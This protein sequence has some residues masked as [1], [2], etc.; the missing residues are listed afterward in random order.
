MVKNANTTIGNFYNYFSSKEDVFAVLVDDLYQKLIYF[1][2]NHNVEDENPFIID[3]LDYIQVRHLISGTLNNIADD[4][5][6]KTIL[7]LECS[8]GTKY[9]STKNI[10][11][12]YIN[13][14]FLDHKDQINPEYQPKEIGIVL[15]KGFTDG[16]ISILKSEFDKDKKID[17]MTE[18]F[19]F[20]AYGTL[21]ILKK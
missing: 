8:K 7:L 13:L 19:L 9:E 20:F 16:A 6:I 21:K 3:E 1:V 15:S 17:L 10:L 5:L 11:A 18:Y 12:D 14:H 4:F 2:N